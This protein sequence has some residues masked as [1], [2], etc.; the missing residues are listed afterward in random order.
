MGGTPPGDALPPPPQRATPARKGARCGADAGSTSPHRPHP[1][2]TGRG[3]LGARSGGRAVG[4]GTAPDTRRPSQRWKAPPPGTPFRHPDSEQRRPARAHA[5]GPV[6]GPHARID[7]TRDTR[8]AE[9]WL[10]AP[11]DERPGEGQR[12]TP[13][14]PHSG[15]RHPPPGTPFRQPHSERRRPA[16]AHAVGLVL[17]PHARID[18]TRDTRVAEPWLHAP[19]DERPGEGQR[20]TPGAPHNGGRHPPRGRPSATPTASNA[21]PQGARCGA[22][23]GSTRPHRP[24]PGHT[25][26]GTLAARSGGR[27]A[28]G[29]TA[30]DTRR[31][32]QRWKAPPP[33]DALPP[34]PQRA[35][36]ACKGARCGAGAGSTR[37]HRPHPGHTGCGTLAAR[38]GGRAAGGGTAPDTRRPS[39]RWKA[40]PP[41]TPFRHPHSE[42]RRPTRAHAVGPVLGPHALIDRTRDTRVTEPWLHAPEDERPGKG[43]RLTPGAP[44]NG[45]R[46]PPR[47]RPSAT[48]TASNAGPQG[49]TLW[50]RCWVHTPAST[51]PGTH[52]SQ[53]PGCTL[54]RTSGRGGDSA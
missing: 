25:G 12:L 46:H 36:P 8:V 39:Q 14:A 18:R 26:R 50:G 48:P 31:P 10:H 15:G 1:G 32:S 11:E 28:G 44:H 45:G 34:P 52:G 21:G 20:L 4:G 27:A 42:Q 13:G 54:R 29:G 19:E 47:G 5:V 53:N 37:P 38:S 17:G 9:P 7:R 43:Q 23:A 2:H 51:A 24:H 40:P 6:L 41:G 33:G 49:R 22:G 30:P 16:R 3:T 35:T